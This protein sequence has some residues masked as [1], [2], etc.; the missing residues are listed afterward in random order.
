MAGRSGSPGSRP[1]SARR[2]GSR[3][4]PLPLLVA[5][6][7]AGPALAQPAGFSLQTVVSGTGWAGGNEP[8]SLA[9]TP[10]GSKLFFTVRGGQLRWVAVASLPLAAG[11]AGNLFATL[12]VSTAG[13]LGLLGVAVDPDYATNGYVYAWQ[14]LSAGGS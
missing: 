2:G 7:L 4:R 3:M 9:F 6:L 11:N 12:A 1:R 10:D 8:D 13:E 14:D 5:A